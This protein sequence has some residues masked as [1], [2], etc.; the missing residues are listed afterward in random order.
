MEFPN[1]RYR[2][3]T[4]GSTNEKERRSGGANSVH[5]GV[6]REGD[7]RVTTPGG[8]CSAFYLFVPVSVSPIYTSEV[9]GTTRV[10]DVVWGPHD[11]PETVEQRLEVEKPRR[12]VTFTL[13]L[14]GS[15]SCLLSMKGDE[16]V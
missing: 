6:V 8:I 3:V 9:E 2:E 4:D 10:W 12:L 14:D 5:L 16:T 15:F 1:R 11:G 7:G 13:Y